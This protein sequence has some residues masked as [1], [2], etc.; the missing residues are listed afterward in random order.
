MNRR[1]NKPV[2]RYK[3]TSKHFKKVQSNSQRRRSMKAKK[4]FFLNVKNVDVKIDYKQITKKRM[5]FKVTS[6]DKNLENFSFKVDLEEKTIYLGDGT[7]LGKI[8]STSQQHGGGTRKNGVLKV[9]LDTTVNKITRNVTN[10]ISEKSKSDEYNTKKTKY[11][12]IAA[13]TIIVCVTI[14]LGMYYQGE[15]A[16]APIRHQQQLDKIDFANANFKNE[17][18][19]KSVILSIAAVCIIQPQVCVYP[20]VVGALDYVM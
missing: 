20:F 8:Q 7:I 18:L 5:N 16:M 13:V 11:I 10:E 17:I 9:N 4:S 1:I 14:C 2:V 6:S 15:L 12:A 3:K 19:K